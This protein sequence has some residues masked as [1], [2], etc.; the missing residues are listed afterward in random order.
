M[1]E[2][3]TEYKKKDCVETQQVSHAYAK[4][5]LQVLYVSG[6]AEQTVDIGLQNN[7]THDSNTKRANIL[8]TT[9]VDPKNILLLPIHIH[10]RLNEIIC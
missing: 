5:C 6:T 10:L 8:Q 9:L 7:C 3:G 2:F 4:K 1:N